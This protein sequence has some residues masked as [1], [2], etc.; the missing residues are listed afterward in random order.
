MEQ[1]RDIKFHFFIIVALVVHIYIASF[2]I[3]PYYF[4]SYTNSSY[5]EQLFKDII[6]NST[7]LRDVVVNINPDDQEVMTNET[8]LS[9]VT[10]SAKGK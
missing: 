10:S 4:A 6:S 7:E 2:I 8:L 9:D 3:M 5:V 1:K